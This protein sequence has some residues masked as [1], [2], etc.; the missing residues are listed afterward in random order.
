MSGAGGGRAEPRELSA[1][2]RVFRVV[3]AWRSP[4]GWGLAYGL[5]LEDGGPAPDDRLDR[6][7]VLE[8]G[9]G[10]D[11]AGDQGLARRLAEGAGLTSTERRILDGDGRA[12]LVQSRGPVWAEGEVAAGLTSL[13]FTSL[14]GPPE[15]L[16]AGDG[17]AGRMEAD[18]L[19]ARLRA[20]RAGEDE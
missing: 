20:A 12:W 5:A 15:R 9:E 16:E 17:H 4:S 8:P 2:G 13:L 19:R 6:R 7:A 18:A 11:D 1:G 3:E 10:L 14:E